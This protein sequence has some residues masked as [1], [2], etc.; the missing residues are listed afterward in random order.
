MK[1]LSVLSKRS[2]VITTQGILVW[3]GVSVSVLLLCLPASGQLNLG[4]ILGSISDQSGGVTPLGRS[5]SSPLGIAQQHGLQ[6]RSHH[7]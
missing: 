4:R 3:V 2:V 6:S 7:H 1:S 5:R